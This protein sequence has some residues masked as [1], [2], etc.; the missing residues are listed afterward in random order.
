MLIEYR[1]RGLGQPGN[2]ALDETF[3]FL[4]I[5]EG[6]AMAIIEW[7]DEYSVGVAALDDD[8]KQLIDIINKIEEAENGARYRGS[9]TFDTYGQHLQRQKHV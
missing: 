6:K 3:G 7:S 5:R 8:H 2:G 1:P 9:R 4:K